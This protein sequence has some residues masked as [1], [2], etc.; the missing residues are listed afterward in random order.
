MPNILIQIG[1]ALGANSSLALLLL[2]CGGSV[3]IVMSIRRNADDHNRLEAKIDGWRE[4]SREEIK[5]WRKESR[6]EMQDWRKE[7]R[8]ELKAVN[9]RLDRI[10]ERL[11]PKQ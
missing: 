6:D 3:W 2:L 9:S 10:L 7:S 1:E 4:E 8:D 5:G 11:P